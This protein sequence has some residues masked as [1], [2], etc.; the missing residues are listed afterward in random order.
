MKVCVSF[1]IFSSFIGQPNAVSVIIIK[2]ALH[3]WSWIDTDKICM[4][5]NYDV[6]QMLDVID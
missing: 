2:Q 1:F 4:I 3:G 5:L 6:Q